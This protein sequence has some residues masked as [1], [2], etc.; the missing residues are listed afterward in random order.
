MIAAQCGVVSRTVSCETRNRPFV[1]FCGG[2]GFAGST[3][4]R[5]KEAKKGIRKSQRDSDTSDKTNSK[6]NYPI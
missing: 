3:L 1:Q 5:K 4:R 6:E 2:G